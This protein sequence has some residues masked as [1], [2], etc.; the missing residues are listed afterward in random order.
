MELPKDYRIIEQ[1]ND[2]ATVTQMPRV[3]PIIFDGELYSIPL[4]YVHFK[5]ITS[6]KFL[7]WHINYVAF[8]NSPLHRYKKE[9]QIHWAAFPN[10]LYTG[11][12]CVDMRYHNM[13]FEC[14]QR[15]WQEEFNLDTICFT[16]K[17]PFREVTKLLPLDEYTITYR[18]L[19][20]M[21]EVFTEWEKL[22]LKDIRKVKWNQGYYHKSAYA[23]ET[24]VAVPRAYLL[25]N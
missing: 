14:L 1:N 25:A 24:A 22:S 5:I 21:H 18:D 9:T 3:Q 16:L 10:M 20:V 23:T 2:S 4:P 17:A 7:Q 15:F 19:E 8:T 12:P 13:W 6:K 11:L